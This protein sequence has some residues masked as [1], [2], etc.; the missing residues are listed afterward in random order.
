MI[1][2]WLLREK[3]DRLIVIKEKSIYIGNIKS[4]NQINL[5]SEIE[6]GIIPKDMFSIPYSYIRSIESQENK[7][8]IKVYYGVDYEEGIKISNKNIK[9]EIFEFL[10]SELTKFEYN[11]NIPSVFKHTRPQIFAIL[12]ATGFFLWTLYLAIEIGKGYEYEIVGGRAGITGVVLGLAQFGALKVILGYT[13]IIFIA[14][15]SLMKKIK[16]RSL[17]EYLTRI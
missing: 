15:Y 8:L 9:K 13:L 5:I 16:N 7:E 12:I 4:I 1:K 3:H 2:Y 6:K 17:T 11:Q 14:I 10:R